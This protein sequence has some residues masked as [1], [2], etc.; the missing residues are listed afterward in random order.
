[1][2]HEFQ[3]VAHGLANAGLPFLWVVRPRVGRDSEWPV[4]FPHKFLESVGDRGRIVECAPHFEVLTH[5]ATGC[6]WTQSGWFS[7][8]ICE[9][10]PLICSPCFV[11][12][13]IIA[14]YMSDVWKIGVLLK[15]GLERGAIE[16]AIERV[17]LG[18]EGEEIRERISGIKEKLNH[19]LDEGGS[20]HES[21]KSLVD[22]ISSF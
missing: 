4:P 14:R 9:G 3:E 20:S 21:L 7:T 13:P 17:M 10:I 19:S 6:F 5:P 15:D 2:E 18:K 8:S 16:M 12:Q 22:Y 1:M 11:D